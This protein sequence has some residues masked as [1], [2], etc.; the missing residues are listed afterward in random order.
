MISPMPLLK[1]NLKKHEIKSTVFEKTLINK[2]HLIF[3]WN[4]WLRK[5]C[6][7]RISYHKINLLGNELFK[8]TFFTKIKTYKNLDLP[9]THKAKES[10]NNNLNEHNV[11]GNSTLLSGCK[12]TSKIIIIIRLKGQFDINP[13]VSFSKIDKKNSK[14][15]RTKKDL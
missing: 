13:K 12:N 5:D 14:Y 4:N 7:K 10:I 15:F 6:L 8:S 3:T 9:F 1:N 2:P 11:I